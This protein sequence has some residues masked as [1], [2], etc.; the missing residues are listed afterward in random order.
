VVPLGD[1]DEKDV[2]ENCCVDVVGTLPR[3]MD[4]IAAEDVIRAI[5]VYFAGGAIGYLTEDEARSTAKG[6]D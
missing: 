4:L 6:L 1:G 5:E 3:C 2:P